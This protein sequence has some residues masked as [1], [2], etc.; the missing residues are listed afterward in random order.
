MLL[1][2]VGEPSKEYGN[3]F[4]DELRARYRSLTEFLKHHRDVF[5]LHFYPDNPVNLYVSLKDKARESGK[6]QA[7][8]SGE[9]AY[10]QE[11]AAMLS[12]SEWVLGVKIGFSLPTPNHLKTEGITLKRLLLKH[13]KLVEMKMEGNICSYRR[14]QG[15]HL[16]DFEPAWSQSEASPRSHR[17]PPDSRTGDWTCENQACNNRNFAWRDTCNHCGV[18]KCAPP[19]TESD[20][21]LQSEEDILEA[22]VV[23]LSVV[24][25]GWM[26]QAS[27]LNHRSGGVAFPP[28]FGKAVS[29]FEK[30]NELFELRRAPELYVRLRQAGSY[31][32]SFSSP[33]LPTQL[34]SSSLP[35]PSISHSPPPYTPRV[36]PAVNEEVYQLAEG[37]FIRRVAE[38]LSAEDW[39][40][41]VLV[42]ATMFAS[43]PDILFLFL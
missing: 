37:S 24:E 14:A 30:H 27:L 7:R 6:L 9:L 31:L 10:V 4:P 20:A 1:A 38:K 42:N 34:L 22:L 3:P 35:P 29:F 13:P 28:S 15:A 5:R 32:A 36:G 2:Q 25:G 23:A 41:F 11:I 12:L 43:A 39:V 33:P 19:V 8:G 16:A 17:A 40:R 18:R 21:G 26:L